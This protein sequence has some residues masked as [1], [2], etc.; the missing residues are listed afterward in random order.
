MAASDA[1][2]PT[3]LPPIPSGL[4][5]EVSFVSGF[6][7]DGTLASPSFA[8]WNGDTP[9][10]YSAS[11]AQFKWGAGKAGQPGGT[12]TYRFA[13]ASHWTAAERHVFVAGLTL[14]SDE[15]DISFVPAAAG[16][17]TDI[18]IK[19]NTKAQSY[20]SDSEPAH[21]VGTRHVFQSHR[22]DDLHRQPEPV[23]RPD[24]PALFIGRLSAVDGRPRGGSR[25]RPRSYRALQRRHD[26]EHQ[27]GAIRQLR[28][29][30]LFYH[31]LRAALGHP[32][33][34]SIPTT[35]PM[36]SFPMRRRR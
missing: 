34:R 23:L 9:A 18:T 35:R 24:R 28:P 31:V 6:D 19:R 4:D 29:A 36:R 17:S 14:W 33:R 26:R 22:H 13:A 7:S 3:A 30:A 21:P 32:G 12:V 10:T 15:A 1:S 20:E 27:C 11:A 8:T 5:R 25:A 2:N 16:Q